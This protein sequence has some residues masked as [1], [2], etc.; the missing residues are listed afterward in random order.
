MRLIAVGG[1]DARLIACQRAY[2]AEI[3]E[4]FGVAFDPKA[5]ESE[6]ISNARQWHVLALADGGEPIGCGSLRD[7]GDKVGEIKR[8]WTAASVRGL[9]VASRIMDRLE[10]AARDQGY[11]R[12]RLDTNGTL[13][14]AQAMYRKRG[15]R[16]IPR[17]N[18]NPF[19]QHWFEKTL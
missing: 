6:D 18:D 9:G 4:R 13:K 17:Y 15:Y 1:D 14:E 8:V 19:A 2:F 5:G 3:S 12:V 16:E 11:K 10:S 7:L